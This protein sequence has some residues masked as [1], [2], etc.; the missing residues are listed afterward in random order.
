MVAIMTVLSLCT[1][2]SADTLLENK[3][4]SIS[5]ECNK[6]GFTFEIYKVA[7]LV[8][9]NTSP[10]S[11]SYDVLVPEISSA[12]KSGDEKQALSTLD[13][14]E[15]PATATSYGKFNSSSNTEHT[16]S[17]LPQGIYYIKCIGYP[18]D[19]TAVQNSIVSLP[20]FENNSWVYEY[21]KINLAEKVVQN[22]PTTHKSITNS[23]KQNE[24]YTDVALGDTINFKLTNTVTGS[25]QIKL[26]TYAVYDVMSKGLTLN[27]N[28]FKVYLADKDGNK[29]ENITTPNYALNITKEKAGDTTEFNVAL[30]KTY[31]SQDNFYNN[32]VASLNI[33]YSATLNKY[34]I[35]G[36]TG[37]YNE[38]T[39]LEYGN[40]SSK[41]S[42]EGNTVQAYTF[43]IKVEK[44]N[45]NKEHLANAKFALYKTEA[46]ASAKINAIASGISDNNGMV[47]FLTANNE[48]IS[49][50]SGKYYIVE[51]EAPEGYT[52]FGKV[53]PIDISVEY[54]DTAL[55]DT[56]VQ[57]C[58]IDGY[59]TCT[60]TDAKI[61]LPQTGGYVKYVYLAGAG[62]LVLAGVFFLLG[63]KKLNKTKT[64]AD[65]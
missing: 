38:I 17:E 6:K 30:S 42:V 54:Q 24:N 51:T 12:I 1:S 53:I 2:A 46:D 27:K 26:T 4:V 16:F 35:K 29:L 9:T 47:T 57:N 22:P 45:E 64:K 55:N 7:S 49:L 10:Y 28:S 20:Y 62:L 19:V 18:A 32:G 63:R 31:L 58:P 21:D 34:A 37:N 3:N 11:T 14:I 15:L 36:S 52:V 41:T 8:N 56:Y 25:K 33:E 39:K 13:G 43:G 40:T 48:E 50:Q 61:T 59:A 5:V 60:V 65:K 44:L 23:T